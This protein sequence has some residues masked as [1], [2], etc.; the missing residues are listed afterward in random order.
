LLACL[1]LHS[2]PSVTE[3]G[4]LHIHMSKVKK[5]ETWVSAFKGQGEV[6]PFTQQELQKKLMLERFQ[7]EHPGFDFSQASFSG[8]APDARTFMGGVKYQ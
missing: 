6:D 2:L 4:E 3:D 1:P 8:M 5:G 7:E